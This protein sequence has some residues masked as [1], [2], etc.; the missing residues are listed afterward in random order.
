[1]RGGGEL[2]DQRSGDPRA[3]RAGR[4]ENGGPAAESPSRCRGPGQPPSTPSWRTAGTGCCGRLA[5]Q[6]NA[7]RRADREREEAVRYAASGLARDLLATADN[8][9]R[10]IDSVPKETSGGPG[11]AAIA[12]PASKRPNAPCSRRLPS[13][14]SG[15][16]S[17]LGG[18]FDPDRHEAVFEV[19]GSEHPDG[20]RGGCAPGRLPAP[21]P[22]AATGDGRRGQ[23][24]RGAGQPDR[25][26][27]R[28]GSAAGQPRGL[29][30]FPAGRGQPRRDLT[31]GAWSSFDVVQHRA[32]GGLQVPLGIGLPK[33]ARLAECP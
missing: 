11:H 18:R 27:P 30:P 17:A 25:R 26:R 22:A 21:R 15:G 9:R 12:R 19:T 33:D 13:T 8:L 31:F 10:A 3:G 2:D 5:D 4:P 20:R 23:G 14:A 1:M 32:D 16:S 6:E 24:R 29:T 28:S 7:R